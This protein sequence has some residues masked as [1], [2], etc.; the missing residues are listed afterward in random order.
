M[1]NKNRAEI[2]GVIV[3]LLI[4]IVAI[5]ISHIFSVYKVRESTSPSCT[6]IHFTLVINFYTYTPDKYG[7]VYLIWENG[8]LDLKNSSTTTWEFRVVHNVTT[9]YEALAYCCN[10]LNVS[11]RATYW[12]KYNDYFIEEICGVSNGIDGRYWQ[13]WVN[14]EYSSVG[15]NHFEIHNGDYVEWRFEKQS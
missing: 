6:P 5:I 12:E 2:Y 13:F 8:S 1:S 7:D 11:F 3:A 14:G 9:V 10:T 4:V 15:A